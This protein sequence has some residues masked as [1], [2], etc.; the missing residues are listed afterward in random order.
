MG[1]VVSFLLKPSE[2]I[3]SDRKTSSLLTLGISIPTVFFPGITDTLVDSEL[4]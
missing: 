3:I 1:R 4:V 2:E